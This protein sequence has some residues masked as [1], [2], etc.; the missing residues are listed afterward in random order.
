MSQLICDGAVL[1]DEWPLLGDA[2]QLP[3]SHPFIVSWERWTTER[4]SLEAGQLKVGLLLPNTLDVTA[5]LGELLARPL[6][7]LSFPA[8]GDGRAYS[9][10][11][12]LRRRH[13][14]AGELRATGQAVV[15]DQLQQMR[16]CG[17]DTFLLRDDQDAELCAGAFHDLTIA[18]QPNLVNIPGLRPGKH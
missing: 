6:L 15:R 18:Y 8:F 9:Q 1:K 17:F 11:S 5:V 13:H 2:D 16:N 3:D 12:L 10:A 14:Y 4:A 7:A